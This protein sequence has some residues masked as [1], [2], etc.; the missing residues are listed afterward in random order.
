[1]WSSWANRGGVTPS[2]SIGINRPI[3]SSKPSHALVLLGGRRRGILRRL[4]GRVP[5]PPLN[6]RQRDAR[7]SPHYRKPARPCTRTSSVIQGPLAGRRHQR[8]AF[9]SWHSG[10][11]RTA[12]PIRTVR[13]LTDGGVSTRTA[14]PHQ[15]L[16]H[17]K[18]TAHRSPSTRSRGHKRDGSRCSDS[19]E[20]DPRT[21]RVREGP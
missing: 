5:K 12:S 3:R 4:A 8:T 11:R 15:R 1:M 13:C 6:R 16:E 2:V 9:A 20:H 17:V 19:Q 7:F 21:A 14:R 18:R 10:S